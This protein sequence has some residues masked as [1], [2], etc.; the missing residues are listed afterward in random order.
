MLIS[1]YQALDQ[2]YKAAS[3]HKSLAVRSLTLD[4]DLAFSPWVVC[5][6]PPATKLWLRQHSSFRS[7]PAA[8]VQLA[9]LG[10]HHSPA[11]LRAE[12][13]VAGW[14]AGAA[15]RLHTAWRRPTYSTSKVPPF[16]SCAACRALC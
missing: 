12:L 8:F 10:V 4:L 6:W 2:A 7:R 9:V 15:S 5:M 13:A 11:R 16:G 3:I 1:L 14:S